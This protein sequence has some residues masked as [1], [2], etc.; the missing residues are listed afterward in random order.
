VPS[1]RMLTV[2]DIT[3]IPGLDLHVAAG[4]TGLPGEVGWVHVSELGDPTPFLEG[5]EFLLTTGLGLGP[6]AAEQRA[7]IRRLAEHGLAGLGFGVGFGF[8]EIPSAI[9]QEA[10]RLGFPIVAIPYEVPFVAITKAVYTELANEQLAHLTRA[11]TVH[12]Q[13][14]DA[15]LEGRGPEALLSIVCHHLGCS[16]ALVDETGRVLAERHSGKRISFG[17]ALELPVALHHETATLKAARDGGRFGEYDLLVLHHGQT[18]LAF[19]LSRRRAVGAAELRLAGDLLEDLEVG[20][21]EEREAA[22]RMTAFGL[23]PDARY[24]AFLALPSNGGGSERLR[25]EVAADLD[26]LGRAHL[27]T[28]RLDRAEFLVTVTSEDDALDLAAQLVESTDGM[29]IAVG[30][31]A[32]GRGLGRSMLEARAAL[33]AGTAPVASYRDLGSLELLLGLPDASLE[34][35]VA[36]VLGAVAD[37][38]RLLESLTALLDAGG[39]W[40]DAAG[41]LGIHRHTLR[42]RMDRLQEQTGRHPDQPKD[43]MELWL[44]VKAHQA[45]EARRARPA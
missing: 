44:A 38:A 11:L 22:R 23:D 3:Q 6:D 18:A 32:H 7:Y 4:T 43:Q 5:R 45:L 41:Q 17:A 31:P 30:R 1:R 40:T 21:I 37:N 25:H 29:R 9:V 14:A 34:A 35:F 13:L 36:R 24:A 39:R 16:L 19:E 27:S 42:Y 2:E 15:V 26:R 28:A 8:A 20:R 12:E 10:D 33:D